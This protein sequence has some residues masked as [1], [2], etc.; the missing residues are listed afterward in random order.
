MVEV[1][2]VDGEEDIV[3]DRGCGCVDESF[4]SV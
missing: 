4:V 1:R 3:M 2:V